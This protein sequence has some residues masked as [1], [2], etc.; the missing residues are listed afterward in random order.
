MLQ[1]RE[2]DGSI[3]SITVSPASITWGQPASFSALRR[4]MIVT[5][6]RDGDAP[7]IEVRAG[8]K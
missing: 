5:V 8:G 4:N 2:R 7:A 3:V 1:L 6:I